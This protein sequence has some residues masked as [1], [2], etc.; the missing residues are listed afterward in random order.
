M[1]PEL[2]HHLA[3]R[4]LAPNIARPSA[5][6]VFTEKLEIYFS[7]YLRLHMTFGFVDWVMPFK[8]PTRSCHTLQ[9][10]NCETFLFLAAGPKEA[11]G[12]H[13]PPEWTQRQWGPRARHVLTSQK[14]TTGT[15]AYTGENS[16]K[17]WQRDIRFVRFLIWFVSNTIFF[18]NFCKISYRSN[19]YQTHNRWLS[20]RLQHLNCSHNRGAA[21]LHKVIN[22]HAFFKL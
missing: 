13:S 10:F 12:N 3:C 17:C 19:L 7:G 6:A 4:F 9:H 11:E 15:A 21:V 18:F 20:A 8:W 14:C 2:G 16:G 22:I 5:G 1:A